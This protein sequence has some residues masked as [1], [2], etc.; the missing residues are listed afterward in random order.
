[1]SSFT[2][3][4][5]TLLNKLKVLQLL[6]PKKIIVAIDEYMLFEVGDNNLKVTATNGEMQLA[7]CI[8]I[9]YKGEPFITALPAKFIINTM[10]LWKTK[11]VSFSYKEN[12]SKLGYMMEMKSG[13]NSSYKLACE[14][15]NNFPL[16]KIKDPFTSELL[17]DSDYIKKA[18]T[19]CFSFIDCSENNVITRPNLQGISI[20]L[21]NYHVRVTTASNNS[22]SRLTFTRRD[23]YESTG[24]WEDIIAPR[25]LGELAELTITNNTVIKMQHN[26]DRLFIASDIFDITCMLSTHRFPQMD[27]IWAQMEGFEKANIDRES[28][29]DALRR[30]K[31][32]NDKSNE[33]ILDIT[34]AG[35]NM[36]ADSLL[37]G[38]GG[39]EFVPCMMPKELSIGMNMFSTI[40]LL[41]KIDTEDVEFYYM[42]SNL[43]C[44]IKPVDSSDGEYKTNF[45]I[46][47]LAVMRR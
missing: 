20:T 30:I 4:N 47:P 40:D 14:D 37:S 33:L 21:D 24:N 23:A 6:V 46:M 12:K 29:K 28:F 9:V 31:N 25:I 13:S 16:L 8:P 44:F 10:A 17:V 7:T 2:V 19:T 11:E 43:A 27:S 32:Y 45:I 3:D 5:Y 36:S 41:N 38:H 39:K 42:Q 34:H 15:S 18:L 35:I 26:G 22:A 1:M